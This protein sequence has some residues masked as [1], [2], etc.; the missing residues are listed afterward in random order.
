MLL[1][2]AEWSGAYYLAGY[3][4][5]CGLK[6]CIARDFGKYRMPDLAVVKE[7][8][9]HDLERLVNIAKLR[10]QLD[11]M[12]GADRSFAVNWAVVKD[13]KE[14]SRYATWTE[15]EARDLYGAITQR[16]HGVFGWVKKHW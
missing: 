10:A 1:D 15:S 12:M 8:Y 9:I 3:A 6:A 2:Q 14:T 11:L 4:V 5:E 7:S 13:W 16:R